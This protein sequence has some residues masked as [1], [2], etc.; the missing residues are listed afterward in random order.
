MFSLRKGRWAAGLLTA[1]FVFPLAAQQACEACHGPGGNSTTPG[2]PSIAAQPKLFIENQLVLMREE[3]RPSPQMQ[4]IVKGMKDAEISRLAEHFSRLPAAPAVTGP[5]DSKLMKRGVERAKVLRCGVCHLSDFRGQN[6]VPRLAGQREEYLLN[7]MR[8][9][10]D[11]KRKGGDTIMAA[12]LYG[13]PDEDLRALAHFLSRSKPRGARWSLWS[14]S[15]TCRTL[16]R[17]ES[18]AMIQVVGMNIRPATK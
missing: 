4:P 17:L 14:R 18:A 13:V 1:F 5:V 15:A 3:L 2:I 9:Y 10:R 12:A 11:N 6:Q 8:A 7:E 16:A